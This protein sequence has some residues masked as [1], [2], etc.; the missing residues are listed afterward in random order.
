MRRDVAR[1]A[2]SGTVNVWSDIRDPSGFLYHP[3]HWRDIT[4]ERQLSEISIFCG[5]F[6]NA[7]L[8]YR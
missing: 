6:D 4:L 1:I 5:W 3:T 7:E 2:A 8:G